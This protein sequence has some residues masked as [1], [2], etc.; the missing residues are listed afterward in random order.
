MSQRTRGFG[1]NTGSSGGSSTGGAGFFGDGADGNL[2]VTGTTTLTADKYYDTLIVQSGGIL[3]TSGVKVFCKTLCQVDAG[4]IIQAIGND[5][6]AGG[7]AGA[8]TN[9]YTISGGGAGGAGGT[10]GGSNSSTHST[11]AA[12]SVIWKSTFGTSDANWAWNEAALFNR[13]TSGGRMLN[14]KLVSMGTKTSAD[15]WTLSLTATFA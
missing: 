9:T 14:R 13:A 3:N 10:A 5:G 8:V 4:G 1:S 7:T 12:A 2:T 15:T 6:A 11:S